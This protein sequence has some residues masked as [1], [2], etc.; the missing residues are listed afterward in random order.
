[1]FPYVI[2]VVVPLLHLCVLHCIR[3]TYRLD[4]IPYKASVLNLF[5]FI[6]FL[7]LTLRSSTVGTDAMSYAQKFINSRDVGWA[8][9]LSRGTTERGFALLTK[10]IGEFTGNQQV[11]FGVIAAIILY[12]IAKLYSRESEDPALTMTLFLVLPMFGMFFSG[13]RQS[14]AIALTVPAYYCV[15]ERKKVKFCVF[16]ALAMMFHQSAL[17]LF[18]LYPVYHAR[19]TRKM[20]IWIIPAVLIIYQFSD[21]I[22][23][24]LI[25]FL[26]DMYDG[27]YAEIKETGAYSMLLL[28][29]LLLLFCYI[30]T[31]ESRADDDLIGLRNILVLSV[32]IQCFAS[33]NTIAMRMNYYFLIFLPLLLPKVIWRASGKNV[34][35]C[36]IADIVFCIYFLYYFLDKVYGQQSAFQN[37]PYIPFWA[38]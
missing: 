1:M 21:I 37:Y 22:Y 9:W 6:F 27:R 15:R 12:P 5:F 4:E 3:K 2:L 8:E 38:A 36:R 30:F 33:V 32:T 18:L 16:V 26:P 17:I 35:T 23:L 14:V 28:F 13:F 10:L 7:L 20:L 11:F 19:L 29:S 34:L 31:D 24:F 25:R